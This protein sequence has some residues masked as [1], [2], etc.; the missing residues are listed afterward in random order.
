MK[1]QELSVN[2]LKYNIM[3]NL[4]LN[5]LRNVNG[6]NCPLKR[7]ESLGYYVGYFFGFLFDQS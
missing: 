4:N 1:E 2:N 5:E 7:N 3:K 6:G